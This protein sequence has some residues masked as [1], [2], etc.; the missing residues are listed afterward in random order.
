[1]RIAVGISGGVDS[2]T[3]LALLKEQ[4]HDVFGLTMK[5]HDEAPQGNR[6]CCSPDD[7][8]DAR[9]VAD[10]LQVDLY[11]LNY[12]AAFQAEVVRPFAAA[13]RAGETPN[14]CIVCNARIKFGPLLARARLLGATC[15]ATGHYAR[16][17]HMDGQLHIRRAVDLDKDQSYFLYRLTAAQLPFLNFPLGAL[18]KSEVRAHARRFGLPV[19]AKPESQE[20]CFVGADGYAATVEGQ[21]GPGR[22][23]TFVDLS[24]R[25]LGEHAGIHRFTIGQRRGL[26]LSAAAP[27]YVVRIEADT[28]RVVLGP[29]P[30]LA[31]R[32]QLDDLHLIGAPPATLFV[33]QRHRGP[34][35]PAELRR[36]A[37]GR[38]ELT[39]QEPVVRAAPGQAAVLYSADDHLLGG[40]TVM[41][42]A[43]AALPLLA[44]T[45]PV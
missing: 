42:A 3:A 1:M 29:Q 16:L 32:V 28:G 25:V 35:Q 10:L 36:L 22:V 14:P 41:R 4:G 30:A 23:G 13:Y 31:T 24:G 20:L 6:A 45:A 37:D 19:A 34:L 44:M 15:L 7:L 9:Q 21:G 2:A 8:R 17:G 12:A 38:G 26:G 39:F 11:V 18:S 33:Q 40:G 27:Q 5:T 43:S